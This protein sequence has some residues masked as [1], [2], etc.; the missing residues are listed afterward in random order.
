MNELFSFMQFKHSISSP[1]TISLGNIF[2]TMKPTN[3][4]KANDGA[5]TFNSLK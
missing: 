4:A 3:M 1:A 2:E 5:R